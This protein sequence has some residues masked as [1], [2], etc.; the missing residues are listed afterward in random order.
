MMPNSHYTYRV[1]WSPEDQEHVA[2]CAEFPSLSWL[3]E[4]E[5]EAL[6]GIRSLVAETIEDMRANEEAVPAP[7]ADR[8]YSGKILLRTTPDVHRR[9]A[10]EAAEAKVSLNRYV[11]A[12]LSLNG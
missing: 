9:L 4:D 11:N 5:V 2:T 1:T 6:R 3:D 7:L 10:I 12:K 8:E